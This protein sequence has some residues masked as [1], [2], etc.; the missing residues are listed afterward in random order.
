MQLLERRSRRSALHHDTSEDALGKL[1]QKS[2]MDYAER[3][4]LLQHSKAVWRMGHGN[5]ITYELLT[6]G[7]NL[8]LML[9]GT[10]VI[11]ALVEK[12]QKFVYVASEPRDRALLTIGQALRPGEYAI[13]CTLA[14]RLAGWFRQD[15]F[16]VHAPESLDWD[17]ERIRATEWIPRMINEVA[18]QVAVGLYRATLLAPAQLFFAHVDHADVAAH[19]VLADSVLQEQRGFPLLIDIA[20]H[21][22]A[23]VFGG[24]LQQLTENAYAAAGA[25][26]R[27][28]SE[29]KTRD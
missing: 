19:V 10:R 6:G 12:H 22:C 1:A 28:L 14:D 15:R 11:R 27:Y 3:A 16:R 17:G 20:H 7:A 26:W 2:L 25:P 21:V 8:D 13:V 29:R 18:G 4:V 24:T 23:A 9:A 5:P